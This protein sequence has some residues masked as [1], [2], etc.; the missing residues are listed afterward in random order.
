MHAACTVPAANT[1]AKRWMVLITLHSGKELHA[2]HIISS[3]P[4]STGKLCTCLSGDRFKACSLDK[5]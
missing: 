5:T 3:L 1:R 4:K 2:R